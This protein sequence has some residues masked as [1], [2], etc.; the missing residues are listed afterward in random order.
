MPLEPPE[1]PALFGREPQRVGL[2]GREGS[3]VCVGGTAPCQRPGVG[4]LMMV[5][6]EGFLPRARR[7]I[8]SSP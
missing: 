2:C 7:E 8:P 4:A 3:G 6:N 1:K 5:S